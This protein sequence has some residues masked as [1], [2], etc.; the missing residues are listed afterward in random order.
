MVNAKTAKQVIAAKRLVYATP[1]VNNDRLYEP[2]ALK[3]PLAAR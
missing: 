1:G 2:A 3:N